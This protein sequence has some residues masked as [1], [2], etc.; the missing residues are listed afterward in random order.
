[1]SQYKSR[2]EKT[3]FNKYLSLDK[4]NYMLIDKREQKNIIDI[5]SKFNSVTN[6]KRK[7]TYKKNK[8]Q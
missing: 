1:M 3:H 8:S 7:L 5:R 4:V 6:L 2:L